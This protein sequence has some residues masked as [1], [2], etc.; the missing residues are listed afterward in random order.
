[1]EQLYTTKITRVGTAL[2][3]V[4]PQDIL[5]GLGWKRGDAVIFTFASD[6]QLII[7][8]ISDESIRRLKNDT[9]QNDT[10]TIIID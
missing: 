7:K 4:I 1:M 6:D 3:T 8:K 9:G 10:T 5:R 2:C